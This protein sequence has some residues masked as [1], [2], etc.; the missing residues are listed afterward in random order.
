M[1]RTIGSKGN[2]HLL[3][4]L[5]RGVLG[6]LSIY[7]VMVNSVRNFL[8]L[9]ASSLDFRETEDKDRTDSSHVPLCILL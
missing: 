3:L 8:F 9:F 1:M 2:L 4:I 5:V 6:L 7:I